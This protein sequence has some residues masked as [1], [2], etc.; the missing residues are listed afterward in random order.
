MLAGMIEVV[1]N[2]KPKEG[3]KMVTTDSQEERFDFSPADIPQNTRIRT[4]NKYDRTLTAFVA[5]GHKSVR[6]EFGDSPTKAAVA[7]MRSAIARKYKGEVRLLQ[8]GTEVYLER[9]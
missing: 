4:P 9:K 5:S 1:W 8:R 7:N 3:D 2:E 6:V